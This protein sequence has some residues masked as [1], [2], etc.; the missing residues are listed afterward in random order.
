MATLFIFAGLPGTGKTTLSQMLAQSIGAV[1]LRIDTIEQGL[2]EL[3]EIAVTVEGYR[4]SYRIATDNL[5]LDTSVIADS[6]NPLEITRR[7]WEKVALEAESTFINIEVICSDTCEHRRRIETRTSSISGLK[8]PSWTEVENRE[9]HLWSK[10]RIIIDT[11][12]KSEHAS[13][14]ELCL[15]LSKSLHS[16]K[17]SRKIII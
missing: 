10:D 9:Y 15:K 17:P 2:R 16:F 8:L 4:L 7:E 13:L 6:C 11:A 1:H 5:K 14:E 12:N 3:C